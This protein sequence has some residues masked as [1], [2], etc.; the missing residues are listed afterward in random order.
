METT[1]TEPRR[2]RTPQSPFLIVG[3]VIVLAI[4]VFGGYFIGHT[5]GTSSND[6]SS[7]SSL[8]AKASA[9]G[10]NNADISFAQMMVPHHTQ[11]ITMAKMA[12][13][14]AGSPQVKSLAT[15]IEGAQQPEIDQ[16][17][18]WLTS[19]G[20]DTSTSGMDHG[21]MDMGS[22]DGMMSQDD[23]NKLS[24]LSGAEFDHEFLTMMI[25]HHTGAIQMA[26]TELKNGENA[27]ALALAT[28]IQVTQQAEITQMRSLL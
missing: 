18:D 5:A 2:A 24:N 23:M 27:E 1:T 14:Q 20:A 15:K 25:A 9:T 22:S 19:W 26:E 13:M 12:A 17:N 3:A 16:M 28:S 7:M 21:S 6:S 10:H 11:A 8:A 4:G